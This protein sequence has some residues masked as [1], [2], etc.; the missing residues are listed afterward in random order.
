MPG[1]NA[2]YQFPGRRYGIVETRQ[3]ADHKKGHL[4]EHDGKEHDFF[5]GSADIK[6]MDQRH[7]EG[8]E[9]TDLLMVVRSMYD[10]DHTAVLYNKID[11]QDK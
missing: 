8:T 9:H 2:F 10:Q 1:T 7:E 5:A 4:Q 6:Y 3:K 11:H